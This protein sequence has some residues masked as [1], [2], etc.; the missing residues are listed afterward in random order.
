MIRE[1]VRFMDNFEKNDDVPYSEDYTLVKLREKYPYIILIRGGRD[2]NNNSIEYKSFNIYSKEGKIEYELIQEDLDEY[3]K[4]FDDL[5][6]SKVDLSNLYFEDFIRAMT[7]SNKRIGTTGGLGSF[8]LF[9]FNFGAIFDSSGNFAAK[10]KIGKHKFSEK[11]LE[12]ISVSNL[13]SENQK[14]VV[15]LLHKKNSSGLTELASVCLAFLSEIFQL[16]KLEDRDFKLENHGDKIKE[17]KIFCDKAYVYLYLQDEKLPRNVLKTFLSFKIF[18]KDET[19]K[20]NSTCPICGEKNTVVGFPSSYSSINTDKKP[21]NVHYDRDLYYNILI[22]GEC[23]RKLNE[24]EKLLYKIDFFPIFINDEY[25][26]ESI[27]KLKEELKFFGIVKHIFEKFDTK[28]LDFILLHSKKGILYYDYVDNYRFEIGKYHHYFLEKEDENFNL[29]ELK[30]KIRKLLGLTSFFGDLGRGVETYKRYLIHK[31]R[32]KFFEQIYRNKTALTGKDIDE[33]LSVILDHKIRNG[34]LQ[35]G[36]KSKEYVQNDIL[37][38]YL[39]SYLFSRNPTKFVVN[40][41]KNMLEEIRKEKEKI[42]SNG[43]FVIDS[44]EKFGYYLGQIIYYLI[45]KSKSE[46]KMNLLTPILACQSIDTLKRVV[47]EKYIEKYAR[48]LSAYKDFRHKVLATTLDYLNSD[49]SSSF[50]DVKMPFYVGFFDDNIFFE[51][52]KKEEIK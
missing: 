29:E 41:G 15:K 19:V 25:Q 30:S 23:L 44:D 40:G 13:L 38:F 28:E 5:R 32:G 17:F 14:K 1:V 51:G 11:D 35:Y 43:H 4:D 45:Q 34:D 48:E 52:S 6:N 46:N 2:L 3:V 47:L 26:I 8:S 16:L 21:F 20:E 49:L 10:K 12:K 33:I 24:F 37:D 42:V 27:K 36:K 22:C 31:Y 39:N 50:N 18:S 7:D 9:H